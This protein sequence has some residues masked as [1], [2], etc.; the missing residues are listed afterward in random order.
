M[1][2]TALFTVCILGSGSYCIFIRLLPSAGLI[3]LLSH[4]CRTPDFLTSGCNL[5]LCVR[6]L[7][8]A[9]LSDPKK[10]RVENPHSLCNKNLYKGICIKKKLKLHSVSSGGRQSVPDLWP[11]IFDLSVLF[12][13]LFSVCQSG[14]CSIMWW[15]PPSSSDIIGMNRWV[16]SDMKGSS[17]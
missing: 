8:T 1:S 16:L 12:T 15:W 17:F 14:S 10:I 2:S 13:L 11:N 5:C 9:M 7:N 4:G 3:Y 6:V